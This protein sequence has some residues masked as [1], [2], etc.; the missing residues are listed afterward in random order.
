MYRY[1]QPCPVARATEVLTETWTLLIVRELLHGSE[2]RSELA[3]GLPK[4]S[5]SLLGDRLRTLERL[6]VVTSRAGADG[7]KRYRLTE[8]GHELAPIV[9]QLGRWG[10]RWLDSPRVGDLDP[11][12]LM[13]DICREI[14]P[15]RLPAQ[16]LTVEIDFVD[17]S[18]ARR[19]WLVLSQFGATAR[20]AQPGTAISVR[21][22]CTL[23]ALTGVWL[24]HT[25]WLE[26]VRDQTVMLAGEPGAVRSMI[27]S[28]GTS[29]YARTP[30]PSD[31][32]T[33]AL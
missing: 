5:R 12:L 29:R 19:W 32:S 30:K 20:R 11:E 18:A 16:P 25:S 23:G 7:E 26:A 4:L 21:V 10:Q 3:Q 27:D 9:A 13:F 6:G 22:T 33:S 1:E 8:A 17:A 14:D 2:R 28:V 31:G 24:G 15:G